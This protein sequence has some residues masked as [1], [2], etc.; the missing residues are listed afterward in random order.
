MPHGVVG[1]ITP[2]NFPVGMPVQILTPALATGNTVVFKPSEIVPLTGQRV[3]EIVQALLPAGVCVLVHGEGDVGAA[4]VE[5]EIDMIGFTG[6]RATGMSIM[7]SAAQGLKRL[8]LELGGKDPM[9]VFADADL[10]AAGGV[11]GSIFASQ[12]GPSLLRG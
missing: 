7:A 2:W 1:V 10:E 4:L 6:S 5:S 9:V 12:H 8:V 3:A 11:C